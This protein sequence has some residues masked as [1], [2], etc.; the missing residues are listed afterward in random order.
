[1]LQPR[2]IIFATLVGGLAS[3]FFFCVI[4]QS[5]NCGG[6][7]AALSNVRQ[8]VLFVQNAAI[9]SPEHRFC[10]ASATPEQREQLADLASNLWV[11]NAHY[12]VST[13]P[14]KGPS[15]GPRRVLMVC[16]TPFRNVPRSYWM[17]PPPTHAASFSDGTTGLISVAEFQSLDRSTFKPL[18]ELIN[19]PKP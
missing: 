1:M 8:Y 9:E 13:S 11:G 17:P 15:A 6:N 3:A 12:L 19:L 18:D 10:V 2:Y 5:S 14:Y 16:D 7:S 4:T